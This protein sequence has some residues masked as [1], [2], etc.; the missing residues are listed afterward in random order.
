MARCPQC[1][2]AVEPRSENAFFPFCSERCKLVD[3]GKWLGGE[4]RIPVATPPEGEEEEPLAADEDEP[5]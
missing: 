2:K 4:Y 1:R 5:A 3:L